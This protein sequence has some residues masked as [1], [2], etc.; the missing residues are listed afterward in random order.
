MQTVWPP[1]RDSIFGDTYGGVPNPMVPH[2]HPWP[3]RYHG[4]IYTVPGVAKPAYRQR[5][6]ARAPYVGV[7]GLGAAPFS[8]AL[9]S[10]VTGNPWID[11]LFGAGLGYVGAPPS[12]SR[13]A[14]V[15]G[16]AIAAYGFGLA[17]FAGVGAMLFV[18]HNKR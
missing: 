17:G 2:R 7:D 10:N 6:Y 4:P 1:T 3:T 14:W 12:Q 15:I 8:E 16:S 5:P 11:A 13:V 18:A 9:G